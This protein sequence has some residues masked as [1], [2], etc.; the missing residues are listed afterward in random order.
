MKGKSRNDTTLEFGDDIMKVKECSEWKS[1]KTNKESADFAYT[2][3][4]ISMTTGNFR[5]HL[6]HKFCNVILKR[7]GL[8]ERGE[9]STLNSFK[10]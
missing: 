5:P 3:C 9:M 7:L 4:P 10:C 8:F 6:L 1:S 2:H